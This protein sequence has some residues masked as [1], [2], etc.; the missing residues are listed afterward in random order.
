MKLNFTQEYSE[1]QRAEFLEALK[2][3]DQVT[4]VKL[5]AQTLAE[6]DK[7]YLAARSLC[8]LLCDS[9]PQEADLLLINTLNCVAQEAR[10]RQILKQKNAPTTHG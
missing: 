2:N 6:R 1:Q 8:S 7:L 3:N 9:K 5:F 4:L 10:D